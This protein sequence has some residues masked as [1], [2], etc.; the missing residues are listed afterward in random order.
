MFVL[1]Y[2]YIITMNDDQKY[3]K[4]RITFFFYQSK[5]VR[6]LNLWQKNGVFDMDIIQPLMDMAN[7]AIVPAPALEGNE[8]NIILSEQC[9]NVSNNAP[10]LYL[11]VRF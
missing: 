1:W 8:I 5:I 6:V 10:D 3:L 9:L 4:G 7:G 2:F 11:K